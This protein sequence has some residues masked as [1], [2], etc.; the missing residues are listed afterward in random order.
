[1]NKLC[2]FAAMV[3]VGMVGFVRADD[4]PAASVPVP[5][6]SAPLS[7]APE[8]AATPTVAQPTVSEVASVPTTDTTVIEDDDEV[9]LFSKATGALSNAYHKEPTL[10][11]VLAVIAGFM[12][13]RSAKKGLAVMAEKNVANM[14]AGE[15]TGLVVLAA[16][17]G[18]VSFAISNGFGFN[19]Y[20]VLAASMG[21]L[22]MIYGLAIACD[23][24]KKN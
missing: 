7:V 8:I 13:V 12:G 11:S 20:T 18:L 10:W 24:S 9:S 6:V 15:V 2:L 21:A 22:S 14:N 3:L 19:L 23:S 1:M 4:A 5:E 17:T 16:G